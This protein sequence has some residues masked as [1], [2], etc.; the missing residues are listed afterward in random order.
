[1]KKIMKYSLIA[2]LGIATLLACKKKD[3]PIRDSNLIGNWKFEHI[4]T[5]NSSQVITDT[6]TVATYMVL[7]MKE[8][9][10]LNSGIKY[11]GNYCIL[12][13]NGN[14]SINI[15]REDR[16]LVPT[17]WWAQVMMDALNDAERYSI[18][19]D[20]LRMYYQDSW[21]ADFTKL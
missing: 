7:T 18:K 5:I 12:S 11:L 13:N 2:F 3:E 9:F 4:K 6:G 8:D 10:T 15:A 21:Q 1:M 14:I 19:E 20:T 16:S 17:P